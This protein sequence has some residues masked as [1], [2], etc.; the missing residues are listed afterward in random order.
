MAVTLVQSDG[1][2][3]NVQANI[4]SA[5]GNP[6]V[7]I[8]MSFHNTDSV[9]RTLQVWINNG[10]NSRKILQID[11]AA[12]ATVTLDGRYVLATGDSIEAQADVTTVIDYWISGVEVT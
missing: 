11:V 12:D 5:V 10:A 9:S 4:V 1:Q 7:I 6:T 8:G 3:T 2:V